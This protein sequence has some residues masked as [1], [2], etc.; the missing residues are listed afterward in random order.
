[1]TQRPDVPDSF[2]AKSYFRTFR[3]REILSCISLALF[4]VAVRNT[5]NYYAADITWVRED[6]NWLV[7][8]S[9]FFLIVLNH[10]VYML[11]HK[12]SNNFLGRSIHDCFFLAAFLLAAKVL[13]LF[14]D[15]NLDFHVEDVIPSMSTI[16]SM[17]IV[18]VLIEL[19][20]AGFKRI[21]K[22]A[23]WQI[24]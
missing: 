4:L 12:R 3:H 14:K 23:R 5:L 9:A 17:T 21:L 19:A 18:L 11:E 15:G 24:F 10:A 13:S 22:L 8:L 20:V 7:L 2:D 16:I 1:M 6:E